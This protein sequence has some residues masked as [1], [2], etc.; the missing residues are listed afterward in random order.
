M[1]NYQLPLHNENT[2]PLQ[3]HPT[4]VESRKNY[5]FIPNLHAIMAESPALLRA[6]AMIS[7]IFEETSFSDTEK[8][9]ILLSVSHENDCDYC[10][11]A[12]SAVAHIK[13][14]PAD[15][16]AAL[17]SG[18]PL[19]DTKLESLRQLVNSVINNRG[20]AKVYEVNAFLNAGY[21]TGQ[22]LDVLV[23]VGMKTL[24]NYTNHIADTP[25][26]TQFQSQTWKKAS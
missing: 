14:V 23:G 12:H 2:A 1:S 4:L 6:Y 9:L 17:R 24:S 11:A 13:N 7:D 21:S 16:I 18:Q 10:M 20:H 25:L 8:Q 19:V 15:I 3:A 22:L 26:D 5:G